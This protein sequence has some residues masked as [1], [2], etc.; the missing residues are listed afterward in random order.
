[1]D[2]G[3]AGGIARRDRPDPCPLSFAQ[4]RL[5]FLDQLDPQTGLYN[6]PHAVRLRGTLQVGA[7]RQAFNT[8][9]ARH[10]ALRTTFRPHHEGPVQIVTEHAV[11]DLPVI[12]LRGTPA[13]QREAELGRVLTAEARRPFN[14]SSDL[15]VRALLVRLEERE[16]VLLFTVHHI[17]FD[18]WSLGILTRE[19]AAAYAAY[20]AGHAPAF[21]PLPVQYADYAI[22]QRRRL[23]EDVLRQQL[24]YWTHTLR[25]APPVIALPTDRPRRAAQSVRGASATVTLPAALADAL[26]AVARRGRATMFITLLTAFN[27]LLARYTGQDDIVVGAP[28]ANRNRVELEPLIGFFVNTLAMRGDLSGDRTFRELLGQM[29]KVALDAY[30]HQEL[31][32]E[33]LVEALRPER[34]LS[35]MPL[36][37]VLFVLHDPGEPRLALSGLQTAPVEVNTGTAKFDLTLSVG[38]RPAGLRVSLEYN[39]DLY[40]PATIRRMLGHYESLL[41]GIAADPDERVARLPL[42]TEAER[43]QLLVEW[44]AP[45][46]APPAARIHELFE[47]QVARSPEAVAVTFD[48][49]SLTYR[50]LNERANQLA[51]H[52]R[53]HGVGPDV[54]VGLCL[55]RSLEMSVGVIGILKAGGAYVPLDPTYPQHRLTVMLHEAHI[56]VVVTQQRLAHRLTGRGATVV[57]LDADR[58]AI[59][60]EDSHDPAAGATADHL[61][62]V[63]FTSGSTGIPKGVM[64]PHR[65]VSNFVAWMQDAFPIDRTD[66]VFQKTPFTFDMSV[67]ELCAPLLVGARLVM[68]QPEGQRDCRYLVDAIRAEGVTQLHVVPTLLQAMAE[69][70]DFEACTS[71]RRI[72]SAGEALS[73]GLVD[74]VRAQLEV[75]LINLYGPTEGNVDTFWVAGPEPTADF[76]PIG[77]PIANTHV[78]VLDAH[79]QPVPIG[80]P[81][82]VYVGGAGVARGYLGNAALTAERFLQNPFA[83][84][85]GGRLYKTGD[86]GRYLPDGNLEFLGR[87]DHQVKLRGFRI[88]LGEIEA[89]LGAHPDVRDAAVVLRE[90]PS[91]ETRLVGYVLPRGAAP[92]GNALRQFLRAKLPEHMVPSAFVALPSL[93]LTSSGKVDRR[94]LPAPDAARP[95]PAYVG[96]RDEVERRLVEVWE[97]ILGVHPV[98]VTDNFFDLGGHSLLAAR[99]MDSIQR[100]VGRKLPLAMLFEHATVQDLAQALGRQPR[101]SLTSAVTAIHQDGCRRPFFFL[102]GDYLGGGLYCRELA[103]AVGEDQPFFALHSHGPNGRVPGSIEAMAADHVATMRALQP[104]GPYLLGGYCHGGLIAFQMAQQLRGVGERVDLLV[105]LDAAIRNTSLCARIFRV[106]VEGAGAIAGWTPAERLERF[107]RLRRLAIDV[108]GLPR[109]YRRRIGELSSSRGAWAEALERKVKRACERLRPLRQNGQQPP[110][111]AA[112][113]PAH[114]PLDRA[115]VRAIAG[116]V[117]RRYAGAVT[118]IRAAGNREPKHDLGWSG[119]VSHVQVHVTPGDHTTCIT[120]YAPVVGERLAACLQSANSK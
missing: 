22:W 8:I 85:A 46:T 9:V 70:R 19:L 68:A 112:G 50:Q 84:E 40:D 39:T 80:V 115:Y 63:V 111:G 66:V 79:M 31:P 91:G 87:L 67:W 97:E 26:K 62:Y 36:I 34:S 4:A 102:D 41:R 30:D 42:L 18:E 14:L 108:Y 114:T 58:A 33:K 52:L 20:S 55:E 37:Q 1:M 76:V 27:A 116:Y 44:D 105:L 21:R 72:F 82:D 64:I 92:T 56:A 94:K 109:H 57:R 60:Q 24:T 78:Y 17:A 35:R 73:R 90:E 106:L 45:R 104:H 98:G 53:K 6:V 23:Q 81:G 15:M 74:R 110:A 117:P 100:T 25:G 113:P 75:E 69:E 3:D 59:A 32:F 96:P 71:L 89:T 10:E 93:P 13:A 118:L 2:A 119:V 88:E 38:E 83:A 47:A 54:L 65:S 95:A 107:V 101:E 77:R 86:R 11:A 120:E 48:G 99:L 28:I 5:W 16:H 103:R 12:D 43:R 61:F 29:R 51:H 49:R 7:L